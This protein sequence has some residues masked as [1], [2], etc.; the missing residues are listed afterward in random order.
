[1][2]EA[3]KAIQDELERVGEYVTLSNRRIGRL[4]D[5]LAE[6]EIARD[7]WLWREQDLKRVWG[8]MQEEKTCS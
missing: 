7:G 3:K 4:G 8:Q 1:M 6:A 5:E 2:T